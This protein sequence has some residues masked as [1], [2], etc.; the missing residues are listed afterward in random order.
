MR[1]I[2]K[3]YKIGIFIDLFVYMYKY[4]IEYRK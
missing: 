2:K 3:I 1:D 4:E